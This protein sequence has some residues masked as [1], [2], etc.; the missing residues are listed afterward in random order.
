LRIFLKVRAFVVLE[1]FARL[2]MT[3][4]RRR[5]EPNLLFVLRSYALTRWPP[6]TLSVPT[7]F[8]RSEDN[9]QRQ[10]YDCGWSTL[11]PLLTVVP[12]EGDHGS[13]LA[14]AHTERLC[15]TFLEALRA[16][17]ASSG[18]FPGVSRIE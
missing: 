1:A 11:C 16:A 4:N 10:P 13:M 6:K 5:A 12:I 15:A 8:F 2:C 9:P 3:L 17:D 18:S 7:F 14:P